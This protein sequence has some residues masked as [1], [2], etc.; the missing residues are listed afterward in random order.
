MQEVHFSAPRIKLYLPAEQVSHLDDVCKK[1][2]IPGAHFAQVLL[3][4]VTATSLYDPGKHFGQ[5]FITS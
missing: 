5:T 4:L 2:D 1:L 3:L